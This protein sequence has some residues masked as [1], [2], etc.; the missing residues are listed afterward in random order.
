MA[1]KLLRPSTSFIIKETQIKA[2]VKNHNI[3]TSMAKRKQKQGM[4]GAR[5]IE[6]PLEFSFII[7][8]NIKGYRLSG[9]E[10]ISLL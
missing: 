4:V 2:T 7:G 3:P 8:E 6:E 5:G 9:K 10:F 1:Q